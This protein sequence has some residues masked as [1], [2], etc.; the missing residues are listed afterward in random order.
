MAK[1]RFTIKIGSLL[2]RIM[3]TMPVSLRQSPDH[4]EERVQQRTSELESVNERLQQEISER[5]RIEQALQREHDFAQ[6]LI[7]TAQAIIMVL[8]VQ[9]RIVRF[10]RYME[11]LSGYRLDEVQGRDWFATF[12]PERD[13]ERIRGLFLKAMGGIATRGN[14]NAIVAKDGRELDIEWNDNTLKDGHGNIVG[15]LSIGLDVTERK[16]AENAL[17]QERN[18]LR[19]L[20]DNLPDTIYFKDAESRFTRINPAQGRN[21]GLSDPAQAIGK[22]DF[23]FFMEEHA[24]QAYADE[25]AIMETG[26][27]IVSKEERETWSDG[28]VAWV[29]TTKMPLH[30]QE[31]RIVGTFGIS[32]DITKRKQ[33]EEALR[34]SE[35]RYRSLFDGIPIGLYRTSPQGQIIDANPALVHM[36]GYPDRA[37]LCATNAADAYADAQEREHWRSTLERDAMARDHEMEI[38][39]PD[40]AIIWVRDV[41]RAVRDANGTVLY[42]EGSLQDMSERKQAEEL[43]RSQSLKDDLTGLYNRRGFMVLA[44]EQMK[45]ARRKQSSMTLLFYADLDRMKWINDTLGHQEGDRALIALAGVFKN[46]FRESDIVARLGGDEFVVLA[47][48]TAADAAA[49]L[50]RR[51]QEALDEHNAQAERGYKLSLSVGLA[52]YDPLHPCSVHDLLAQADS[53]MYEHKRGKSE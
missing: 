45:L 28:H 41:A 24:Q 2:K 30:N 42:Y 51:L 26:E 27:P 48:D 52:R 10:N 12:L 39:R 23:D 46:A 6:S 21:F 25:Q 13:R 1:R 32:R 22:T 35:Q 31:G 16:Q 44:E 15:V 29:S 18:L 34:E 47:L 53:L 40:G 37:A 3:N 17:F 5:T 4:L 11:E 14:V 19:M 36:L 20:M 9:G 8:D 43:L 33:A 49:T 50:A 7:E 38:R